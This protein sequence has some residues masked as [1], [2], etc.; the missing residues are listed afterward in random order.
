MVFFYCDLYSAI[1][2]AASRCSRDTKRHR[3]IFTSNEKG[4][5]KAALPSFARATFVYRY[6]SPYLYIGRIFTMSRPDASI[7]SEISM[8]TY[9]ARLSARTLQHMSYVVVNAKVAL[10]RS[11]IQLLVYLALS[12]F[13]V[14]CPQPI[15]R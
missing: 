1:W 12:I 13:S 9:Q 6:I 2:H 15:N 7:G 3:I 8:P 14:Y 10:A 4:P 5:F 11:G